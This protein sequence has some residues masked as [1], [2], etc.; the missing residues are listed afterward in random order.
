MASLT[1]E[2]KQA[3]LKDYRRVRLLEM[4]IV[5]AILVG[6]TVLIL[7]LKD[8]SLVIAG[9][10]G[11]ELAIAAG[12]VLLAGLVLHFVHW[13]C[14]GCRRGLQIGIGG[15]IACRQCG[16]VLNAKQVVRPGLTVAESALKKE[17]K[18]YDAVTGKRLVQGIVVLG[19]GLAFFL[20]ATPKDTVPVPF[21]APGW[22]NG[23]R[24][25]GLG[26]MLCAVGVFYLVG[27]RMTVGE[28][29][30]E[31]WARRKLG[32]PPKAAGSRP[33]PEP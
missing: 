29:E 18:I 9:L 14:P 15:L 8:P 22:L 7:T 33:H 1:A 19:A 2:E 17:M 32:M 12:A 30:H 5:L 25:F 24:V 23:L 11:I 27:R 4:P 26:I 13:R 3:I 20:W 28:R 6:A 21:G 31:A 10:G 16:V